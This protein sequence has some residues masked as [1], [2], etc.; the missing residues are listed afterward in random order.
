MNAALLAEAAL[1]FDRIADTLD[2][3]ANHSESGGWSTHQVVANRAE[4]D[5]IRR[6]A[7]RYRRAADLADR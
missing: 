3:W 4:A 6:L 2:G 5:R 1:E 7:S